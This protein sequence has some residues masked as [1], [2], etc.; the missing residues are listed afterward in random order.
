VKENTKMRKADNKHFPC[1]RCG[2]C[3]RKYQVRV[4]I[5][6]TRNIAGRLGITLTEFLIKYTDPRWPGQDSFLFLHQNGG[7]TFLKRE[8]GGKITGC[9]IHLFRPQDCCNWM[10]GLE[11]PECQQG[12]AYWSL[13]TKDGEVSGSEEDVREFDTYLDSLE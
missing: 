4:T 6:E 12:L 8:S 9:T 3:C 5:E 10:P 7:C 13:T 1:F 2:V 11:R